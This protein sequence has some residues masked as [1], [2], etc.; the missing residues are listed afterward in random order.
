DALSSVLR[1]ARLLPTTLV[2]ACGLL[3]APTAPAAGNPVNSAAPAALP[4][5]IIVPGTPGTELVDRRTG[6]L[7]WPNPRQMA[8]RDGN[9]RLALP[10]D[11]PESSEIVPGKLLRAVRVLGIDFPIHAYDGLEARLRAMGYHEGDWRSSTTGKGEY[12]YFVYDWRQSVEST[13]R[14]FSREL[15]ELYRRLPPDT[16]PAVVLGHSLGGLVARYALMYGDTTLG[17]SG[18]LPPVTWAGGPYIG[19]LF[20][21]ATPNQGTFTALKCLEKGTFYYL[22]YGAFSPGTLFTFPSVFDVLPARVE[23]LIDRQ[24]RALPF[25]LDD[26]ADWERLGWSVLNPRRGSGLPKAQLHAHLETELA[27]HA[28]LQ[29]A[30]AQIAASPNPAALYVVGSLSQTVQRTALVTEQ[31]GRIRVQFQPPAGAGH[32][33]SPLLFEPGDTM[34][35]D[36][37]LTAQGSSHDP[38]SSLCFRSVRHSTRSHQGL[39]SSPEILAALDELLVAP[40]PAAGVRTASGKAAP[41]VLCAPAAALPVATAARQGASSGQPQR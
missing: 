9:D 11:D 2:L 26:A 23:P 39:L 24:G 22:H 3:L 35:P 16:P 8:S 33:L 38:A 7:V 27:R 1:P 14:R 21:V 4:P 41:D 34:V 40:R 37:S 15:A 12:F 18:P 5:V 29:A 31:N 19:T 28:R 10:L 25:H 36:R 30:L 32:T 20:L 13:G 6:E 17:T